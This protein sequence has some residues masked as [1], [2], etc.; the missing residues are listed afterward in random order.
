MSTHPP[1]TKRVKLRNPNKITTKQAV[2]AAG[3]TVRLAAA[4]GITHAAV[5]QWGKYPPLKRQEQIIKLYGEK[6]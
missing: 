3:N 4:L 5:S 6:T 2:K 1:T